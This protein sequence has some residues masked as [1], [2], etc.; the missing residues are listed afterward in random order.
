M[1]FVENSPP[2]QSPLRFFENP[3]KSAYNPNLLAIQTEPEKAIFGRKLY[4]AATEYPDP[5]LGKRITVSMR[6]QFNL[7]DNPYISLHGGDQAARIILTEFVDP[8]IPILGLQTRF[9]QEDGLDKLIEEMEHDQNGTDTDKRKIVYVNNIG[10]QTDDR[11]RQEKLLRLAEVTEKKQ[12][13]LVIDDGLPKD[14]FSLRLTEEYQSVMVVQSTGLPGVGS[15]WTVMSKEL[16]KY[17][18]HVE[19]P[20]SP[21]G[22]Q[23]VF[24]E[25]LFQP[26]EQIPE[27]KPTEPLS[28][29]YIPPLRPKLIRKA[30]GEREGQARENTYVHERPKQAT[31]PDELAQRGIAFVDASRGELRYPKKPNL[32]GLLEDGAFTVLAQTMI[33]EARQYPD[34]ARKGHVK[35]LIK[36]QFQLPEETEIKLSGEGSDKL[37]RLIIQ[38]SGLPVIGISPQFSQVYEYTGEDNTLVQPESFSAEDGVDE[39]ITELEGL[40]PEEK[41]LVYICNPATPLGDTIR[42]ANLL[43]L[44]QFV[45]NQG[46]TLV[47]DEAFIHSL[48][49]DRSATHLLQTFKRTMV[50]QSASK[51]YGFPGLGLGWAFMS[52]E[53]AQEYGYLET[54]LSPSNPQLAFAEAL[55]QPGVIDKHINE[56]TPEIDHR[57]RT[58]ISELYKRRI[59]FL[60]T[61]LATTI[62]AVLWPDEQGLSAENYMLA[63]DANV[64]FYNPNEITKR[65]RRITVPMTDHEFYQ[66]INLL[67]W[68][69]DEAAKRKSTTPQKVVQQ[70]HNP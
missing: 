50:L 10:I 54:H 29:D 56:V 17:Y 53:L 23:L 35:T 3:L 22:L 14:N 12:S 34:P 65:L 2:I 49:K 32:F 64:F 38:G 58:F 33:K 69:Y 5:A 27:E 47:I 6:K 30:E 28:E 25:S 8:D 55:F 1:A 7:T 16:G 15:G 68:A 39:L 26:T 62:L 43:K 48:P 24:L 21:R 13:I 36:D 51:I 46:H 45:E 42:P 40:S 18:K 41:R 11:N 19:V 52:D 4:E 60:N 44:I 59:P 9:S 20:Y 67:Q 37:L 70:E 63:A 31:D 66:V 57:K 61:N